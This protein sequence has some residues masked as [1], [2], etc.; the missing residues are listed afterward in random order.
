MIWLALLMGCPPA[1]TLNCS[2]VD[3]VFGEMQVALQVDSSAVV[4]GTATHPEGLAI[5]TISVGGEPA[6]A[7]DFNYA[8]WSVDLP[9][10]VVDDLLGGADLIDVDAISTDACGISTRF[11]TDT[12]DLQTG[13]DP[14]VEDLALTFEFPGEHDYLPA[15]GSAQALVTA[16][17]NVEA[18]GMPVSFGTSLGLLD[19][20][21]TVLLS[22]DDLAAATVAFTGDSPG[23]T[24]ITASSGGQTVSRA[25]N[26]RG[27]AVLLPNAADIDP[28]EA[29]GVQVDPDGATLA[30]C[31]AEGELGA[32]SGG[33]DIK[34]TPGGT[35]SDGDG[36]YDLFVTAPISAAVGDSVTIT[37]VDVF[38]QQAVGTYAVPDPTP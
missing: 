28:G 10:E 32:T 19:A 21:T 37:C 8:E 7:D 18:I 26:V 4:T 5:R 27:S 15:D 16:L 30:S 12:I 22:R 24:L 11:A 14:F 23:V 20:T 17:A 2:A 6:N 31:S 13:P 25:L 36:R 34:T 35:D 38:G 3:P 1:V 29:Y 33:V 9:A